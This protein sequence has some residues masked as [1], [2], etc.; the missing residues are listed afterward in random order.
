M[1]RT[2]KNLIQVNYTL[3][4]LNHLFLSFRSLNH[5]LAACKHLQISNYR[6]CVLQLERD[7]VCPVI[8]VQC[9]V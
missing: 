1:A 9:G 6:N 2:S 4:I 8:A 3:Y 5:V 7:N